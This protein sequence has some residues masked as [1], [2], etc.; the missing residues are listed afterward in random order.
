MH[1]PSP[2]SLS[3]DLILLCLLYVWPTTQ[4]LFYTQK[5]KAKN[6]TRHDVIRI[7]SIRA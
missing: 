1:R 5:P 6:P 7:N 3:R 2:L 4:S